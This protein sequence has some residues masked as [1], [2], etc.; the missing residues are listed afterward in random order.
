MIYYNKHVTGN[1]PRT[2]LLPGDEEAFR[3]GVAQTELEYGGLGH[4]EHFLDILVEVGLE[5]GCRVGVSDIGAPI[6]PS[7]RSNFVLFHLKK[8]PVLRSRY[9]ADED[10]EE[11]LSLLQGD[12]DCEALF[13]VADLVSDLD[14]QSGDGS[15]A[16][17]V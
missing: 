13:V 4:H 16:W 7:D 1:Q 17:D 8:G 15:H 9:L 12:V 10:I 2:L 3:V 11:R 5:L 14:G 6:S